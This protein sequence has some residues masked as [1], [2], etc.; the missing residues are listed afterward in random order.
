[1]VRDFYSQFEVKKDQDRTDDTE[2]RTIQ[3]KMRPANVCDYILT[4]VYVGNTKGDVLNVCARIL[5]ERFC[6]AITYFVILKS[7]LSS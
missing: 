4:R 6:S 7:H 1:M 5:E 3:L 2:R